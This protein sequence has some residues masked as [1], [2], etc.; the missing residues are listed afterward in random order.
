MNIFVLF[1]NNC[2]AIDDIF[3]TNNICPTI[4]TC[5]FEVDFCDYT[6]DANSPL[7]WQRTTDSSEISIDSY[8]D[9][10]SGTGSFS[11]LLLPTGNVN[12]RGRL[13]SQNF[14][15][16]GP[17][18]LQFWYFGSKNDIGSLNIIKYSE[19]VFSTPL[20]TKN[21][22]EIYDWLFGQV[23]V[24]DSRVDFTIIFEVIKTVENT[25]GF[26]GIDDVTIIPGA[27]PPPINCNFEDGTICSWSQ[28]GYDDLDWLPTKGRKGNSKF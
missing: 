13:I 14:K 4:K 3:A 17:E 1:L 15:A 12:L 10:T 23:Q 6:N 22:F 28:F 16:S 8:A 19:Q 25:N 11:Y 20:W 24:G 18:C 21:N 26:I 9:H 27:C 2:L 7:Q 5:D